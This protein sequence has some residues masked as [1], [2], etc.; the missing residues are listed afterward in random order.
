MMSALCI[1]EA[2]RLSSVPEV[3]SRTVAT[4]VRRN[5][6]NSGKTARMDSSIWE[7]SG[8]APAKISWRSVT[9][10]MGTKVTRATERGSCRSWRRTRPAMA[11]VSRLMLHAP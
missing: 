8:S 4:A 7:T 1:G 3:R 10:T 5:M 6:I 2:M 11:N 9:S